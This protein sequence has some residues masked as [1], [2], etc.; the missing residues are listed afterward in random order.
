MGKQTLFGDLVRKHLRRARA[1]QRAL[2]GRVARIRAIT[3]DSAQS[4]VSKMMHGDRLTGPE[5][6][7]RVL[8][9]VEGLHELGGLD[10]VEEADAL[11]EAAGRVGD[12][13]AM[14]GLRKDG[15]DRERQIY[16]SLRH[17]MRTPLAGA[18]S[19]DRRRS[20]PSWALFAVTVAALVATAGLLWR[21][22]E[23]RP[24]FWKE[25]FDPLDE[26][27]WLQLYDTAAWEDV[28][29]PTARLREA[30]TNADFGKAESQ[31]ITVDVDAYPVLRVRAT[32]VDEDASYTV[33]ILDKSDDTPLDVLQGITYPGEQVVNLS[34]ELGWHG[35]QTFTINIWIGGEGKCATFDLVSI[36]SR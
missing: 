13:L 33:Q 5:A 17:S 20:L 14:I 30:N 4:I 16:S 25:D 26:S 7:G 23:A 24:A 28:P 36:E 32:A 8:A 6:R 15:P 1:S 29:G 31:A 34:E 9:F 21:C 2:A 12:G 10:T 19:G 22:T 11:L 18:G 35:D 27:R 3:E